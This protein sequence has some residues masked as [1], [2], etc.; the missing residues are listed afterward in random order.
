[1]EKHPPVLLS[2]G[3]LK[4]PWW[5][6][7][8]GRLAITG[9]PV[10]AR[11]SYPCRPADIALWTWSQAGQKVSPREMIVRESAISMPSRSRKASA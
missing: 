8:A 10:G 3:A 7:V 6:L 2:S 1:M 5:R 9:H 11:S 4:V